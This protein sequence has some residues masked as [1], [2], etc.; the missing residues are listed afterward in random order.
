M[1][2]DPRLVRLSWD[3][4]HGLVLARRIA[5]EAPGAPEAALSALYALLSAK[6]AAVL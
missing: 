3:H 2:R 5:I 6:L 1:K 4:H